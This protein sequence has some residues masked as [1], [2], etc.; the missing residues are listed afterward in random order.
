MVRVRNCSQP[1][2]FEGSCS[3]KNFFKWE[4][5]WGED[6]YNR[7]PREKRVDDGKYRCSICKDSESTSLR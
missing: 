7:Y 1:W 3:S 6:S 5:V 4:V 2:I